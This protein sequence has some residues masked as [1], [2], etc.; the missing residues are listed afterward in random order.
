MGTGR[1]TRYSC[2]GFKKTSKLVFDSV[3]LAAGG[4]GVVIQQFN[5]KKAKLPKSHILY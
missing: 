4:E 2:E 1:A 5:A 3:F